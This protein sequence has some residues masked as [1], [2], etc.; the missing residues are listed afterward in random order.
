[1]N[2]TSNDNKRNF[3]WSR[4]HIHIHRASGAEQYFA[5][6][7]VLAGDVLYI[8]E[9]ANQRRV[10]IRI[11]L[12]ASRNFHLRGEVDMDNYLIISINGADRPARAK[13]AHKRR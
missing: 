1:M 12:R 5:Y 10:Y 9:G 11:A 7:Y 6:E 4:I 3:I 13:S 2:Y 8:P